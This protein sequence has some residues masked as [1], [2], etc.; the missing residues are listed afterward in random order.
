MLGIPKI[1]SDVVFPHEGTSGDVVVHRTLSTRS[2]VIN[3]RSA[4]LSIPITQIPLSKRAIRLKDDDQNV[5]DS[6]EVP[7]CLYNSLDKIHNNYDRITSYSDVS[8]V[9]FVEQSRKMSL[10]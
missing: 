7:G 6:V 8:I 9:P 3:G 1:W 4:R 2:N 10:T 5:V